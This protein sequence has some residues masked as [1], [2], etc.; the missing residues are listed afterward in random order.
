[1]V[2]FFLRFFNLNFNI[3][4]NG[5]LLDDTRDGKYPNG[6]YHTGLS[7]TQMGHFRPKWYTIWVI[8]WVYNQPY[9]FPFGSSDPNRPPFG[10]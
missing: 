1:M 10:F 7:L 6:N 9:L 3:T 5:H 2:F 4:K 8:I